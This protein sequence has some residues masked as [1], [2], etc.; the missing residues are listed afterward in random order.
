[1]SNLD[2]P[3]KEDELLNVELTYEQFCELLASSWLEAE[4]GTKVYPS[5]KFRRDMF[6]RLENKVKHKGTSQIDNPLKEDLKVV[7][8]EDES[9]L[10][11]SP[12]DEEFRR[13]LQS[14]KVSNLT[15]DKGT[16]Y[17][18][19]SDGDIDNLMQLIKS[20]DQRIALEAQIDEDYLRECFNAVARYA[21]DPTELG[22]MSP[23]TAL[24]N[25]RNLGVKPALKQSQKEE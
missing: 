23:E 3:N 24:I 20:R 22:G 18:R 4:E 13:M 5:R 2:T 8:K 1:M 16:A 9:M 7:D 15:S 14:M 11:K 25:F 17:F 10:R 12:E 19:L 21:Q 6:T